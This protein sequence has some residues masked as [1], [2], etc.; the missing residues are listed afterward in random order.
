MISQEP[1]IRVGIIDRRNHIT[2]EFE[3]SFD[4]DGRPFSGKF[5]VTDDNGSLSLV[6]AEGT[7]VSR[8]PEILCRRGE[9]SMVILHDVTIGVQ[10]HWERSESQTFRGDLRFIRRA[11]GTVAAV[12][13]I[14]L[15]EY[16]ASVTSSEMSPAAPPEFLKA[17]TIA[18]RSWI[19][20]MLQREQKNI[21]IPSQ[22]TRQSEREL[23]RWYDREDHDLYDVCADDHC[24]RYQ[25]TTK[26]LKG[27]VTD[28]VGSTRGVFLVHGGAIC[29]ARF[30]K[31][32]GGLTERYENCW[33]D[34]SIPYLQSISDSVHAHDPIRDERQAKTW[35]RSLPDA[36]CH[37]NDRDLLIR[38]LPAVDQETKDFFR[39][40]QEYRRDDLEEI[41]HARSGIDFGTLMDLT[42]VQRGPS[43]RIVRL[44]IQGTKKTL[45]VGKEL[46][47]RRWLSPSHLYS[48][49]FV[50]ETGR[51]ASGIPQK[52]VLHG[53]GWGHGVGLCQIGAA[54]MAS[55]GK[56]A[57]E[58]LM[59]Y[60][61]GSELKRMYS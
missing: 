48:S 19:A 51:D 47:I 11:D 36:Y 21:G 42:P 25:G 18:S 26:I 44:K 8:A 35:I 12:N 53:C 16:L 1:V 2:G 3:G 7:V 59:H 31:S 56:S 40:K 38:I 34:T 54:V 50:V 52:W 9:D 37:T 6:D 10:F 39:W 29:D 41:L 24:Q 30:S 15:E 27:A 5:G 20:A 57:E 23:I 17:H 60:Y 32:C 45:V 13:L 46:E 14:F 55:Q 49:A 4:V 61:R 43:G 22:R 28:A 33:E 58:I